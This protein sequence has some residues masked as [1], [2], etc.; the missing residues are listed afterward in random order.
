MSVIRN[1]NNDILILWID[2]INLL[3]IPNI[4]YRLMSIFC[5]KY[6]RRIPQSHRVEIQPFSTRCIKYIDYEK[7]RRRKIIKEFGFSNVMRT[8]HVSYTRHIGGTPRHLNTLFQLLHAFQLNW[9]FF[10][11]FPLSPRLFIH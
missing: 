5:S 8:M 3:H 2:G 4:V 7:R 11:D 10:L 1:N 9:F 6:Y